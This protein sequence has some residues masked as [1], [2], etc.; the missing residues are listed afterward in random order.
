MSL[1]E[2]VKERMGRF[3]ELAADDGH[4]SAAGRGGGD[5]SNLDP[6]PPTTRGR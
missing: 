1:M 3:I 4:E 5:G 2:Y 6:G